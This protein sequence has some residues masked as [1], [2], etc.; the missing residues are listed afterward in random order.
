MENTFKHY[1][2]IPYFCFCVQENF[3]AL[4]EP[5]LLDQVRPG[6]YRAPIFNKP[7][8]TIYLGSWIP[9]FKLHYLKQNNTSWYCKIGLL[10]VDSLISLRHIMITYLC[11]ATFTFR[12]VIIP[13]CNA[14]RL[15]SQSKKILK[16]T[17]R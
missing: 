5:I 17:L 8:V 14:L 15:K 16:W 9:N 13:D 11:F 4:L 12:H 6:K 10:L 1:L 2:K 3:G 7:Q